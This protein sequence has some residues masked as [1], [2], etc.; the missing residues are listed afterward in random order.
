[1]SQPSAAAVPAA[2]PET[3]QTGMTRVT[4]HRSSAA[5]R[6]RPAVKKIGDGRVL[7]R[8]ERKLVDRTAFGPVGEHADAAFASPVIVA[9]AN[10]GLTDQPP[11]HAK[12]RNRCHRNRHAGLSALAPF[13]HI[14]QHFRMRRLQKAAVLPCIDAADPLAAADALIG[15]IFIVVR[16]VARAEAVELQVA[17]LK[18]L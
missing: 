6:Q 1:M 8:A 9:R 2:S 15:L 3:A 17:I 16:L 11:R 13:Q 10:V 7:Q 14:A 4:F 18:I 5:E 12:L